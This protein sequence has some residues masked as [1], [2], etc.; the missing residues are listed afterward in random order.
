MSGMVGNVGVTVGIASTCFSVQISSVSHA[1][2]LNR[3]FFDR[4]I[5]T[6]K[7][8]TFLCPTVYLYK[9]QFKGKQPAFVYVPIVLTVN[10]KLQKQNVKVIKVS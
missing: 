1:N 4:V 5:E 8:V 10:G 3:S 6:I 9:M 2:L 7:R